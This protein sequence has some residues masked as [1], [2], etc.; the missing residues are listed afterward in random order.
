MSLDW[1]DLLLSFLHDP[2]DKALDIR[3]HESRALTYA[4]AALSREVTRQ[5]LHGLDDQ[6]AAIAERLPMPTAGPAGERGVTPDGGRLS[7]RHPISGQE[8]L[9]EGCDLRVEETAAVISDLARGIDDSRVRFLTLWRLL[10]ER[11]A[12]SRPWYGRVP[13]D[14]RVPDHTIWNH[15]DITA[16]MHAALREAHGRAFLSLS[17]GPVQPFIA[18]ARSVRDL[19]TGS[20]ILSWLTFQGLLPIIEELGPTAVVFPAL[21][22]TPLLD[23]WLREQGVNQVE[24]PPSFAKKTPCIPNR[25]LAVVPWGEGGSTARELARRC[26]AFIRDK[27]IELTDAVRRELKEK[28]SAQFPLWDARWEE[29]VTS[30]FEVRTAVLPEL[31]CNEEAIAKL[32][33]KKSF[34]D[35]QPDAAKVRGLADSLPSDDRPP[36]YDQKSCGR[37][38]ARRNQC[39]AAG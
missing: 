23:V 6:L 37:W 17:I 38:E 29:Q 12:E 33:G 18:A 34:D 8:L 32:F 2:P 20:A 27:W 24:P 1:N 11:L 9:L 15:L 13:A 10:P 28:L 22:G 39:A 3:A 14:T 35:A 19:W 36:G 25:F 21:R 5:E 7:V 31:E 26:E 16:G 4:A 30:F